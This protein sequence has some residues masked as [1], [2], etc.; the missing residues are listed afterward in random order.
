M[1]NRMAYGMTSIS[2]HQGSSHHSSSQHGN[3]DHGSNQPRHTHPPTHLSQHQPLVRRQLADGRQLPLHLA[4]VGVAVDHYGHAAR[5]LPARG[6]DDGDDERA[7]GLGGERQGEV[8]EG[9]EGDRHLGAHGANQRGL[10]LA[11]GG[12]GRGGG[13]SSRQHH[14]TGQS[15]LLVALLPGALLSRCSVTHPA[16]YPLSRWHRLTD[17]FNHSLTH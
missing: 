8:H 9:I 1:R 15:C 7:R 6:G 11:L 4:H 3:D 17:S 13:D 16:A 2:N 12:G 5:R 10:V 14:I